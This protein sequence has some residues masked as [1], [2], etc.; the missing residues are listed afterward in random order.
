MNRSI[1]IALAIALVTPLA[2]I[3]D[4]SVLGVPDY[5]C[6]T[7]SEWRTH[8]YGAPA[9]G[10]LV[11]GVSDNNLEGCGT[12]Y[13]SFLAGQPECRLLQSQVPGITDP[14][15]PFY[16]LYVR[17]CLTDRPADYDGDM[18]YAQGGAYLVADSG[19]GSTYGGLACTGTFGHHLVGGTVYVTD[20]AFPEVAFILAADFSGPL[21]PPP[22]PGSPDCGDGL[23]EPCWRVPRSGEDGS[24]AT[25]S[26]TGP[27]WV[28]LPYSCNPLDRAKPCLDRCT[29][30][31]HPGSNGAYIVFVGPTEDGGRS[32]GP[33]G[34]SQGHVF[35]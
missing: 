15:H 30:N 18:E 5:T 16:P 4:P 26:A 34:A 20:L 3:A 31:F 22:L 14:S 23:I 2:A 21:S 8:D 7:P 33:T 6:Q 13:G 28:F 19:N 35:L 12:T 17:L 10:Y 11:T 24:A 1:L 25:S 9:N 32:G 27:S 29:A